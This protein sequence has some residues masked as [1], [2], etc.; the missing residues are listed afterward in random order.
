[1]TTENQ[2]EKRP[3]LTLGLKKKMEGEQSNYA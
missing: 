3:K 2:S 1:M